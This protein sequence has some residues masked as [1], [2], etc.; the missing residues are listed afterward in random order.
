MDQ[1]DDALNVQWDAQ[2]NAPVDVATDA[3]VR[4][5]SAADSGPMTTPKAE[6]PTVKGRLRNGT[7]APGNALAIKHGRYSRAVSRALLP[8]QRQVLATLAER[9]ASIIAD[10]G[11]E[12]E[13]STFERD[14]VRRYEEA[15]ALLDF[16]APRL[17]ASRPAT[18][19]EAVQTFMLAL[20]RQLKIIQQLGLRRRAKPVP[21]MAEWLTGL[22]EEQSN[23]GAETTPAAAVD[24]ATDV[25]N[26]IS[27]A[28]R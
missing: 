24:N 13:L 25:V 22:A 26:H 5:V 9:E 23:A 1:D 20:D 19:R 3:A 21:T 10:L 12:A 17:F 2:H 16:I 27:Q 28:E 11:G 8:E 4:T 6:G 15:A 7:F 14:L 18:R